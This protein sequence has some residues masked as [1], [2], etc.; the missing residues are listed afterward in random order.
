[1]KTTTIS[2]LAK[3][4]CDALGT[5]PRITKS[6]ANEIFRDVAESSRT[7]RQAAEML[8]EDFFGL[9]PETDADRIKNALA[10]I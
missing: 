2:A 9:D 5:Q 10:S 1:M 4:L 6:E 7:R 3:N 8:L